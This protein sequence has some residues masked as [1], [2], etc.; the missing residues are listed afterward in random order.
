V[1]DVELEPALEQ[2]GVQKISETIHLPPDLKKIGVEA[3]GPAQPV[4][5]T[6]IIKLPLADDKIV[7]G[8]KVGMV[9]SFR[10]LAE[11]CWRELLKKHIQLVARGNR[12]TRENL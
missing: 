5:Y 9:S 10:W 11:W 8:R 12:I 2:A 1:A 7:S 3:V 4:T 6:G